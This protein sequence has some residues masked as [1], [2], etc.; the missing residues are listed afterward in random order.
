MKNEDKN[1]RMRRAEKVLLDM[2]TDPYAEL[3]PEAQAGYVA[4]PTQGSAEWR[5]TGA[6]RMAAA[7]RPQAGRIRGMRSSCGDYL[8]EVVAHPD[9]ADAVT[10]VARRRKGRGPD[11]TWELLPEASFVLRSGDRSLA[12]TLDAEG[13]IVVRGEEAGWLRD[14]YDTRPGFELSLETNDEPAREYKRRLEAVTDQRQLR[15]TRSDSF[16]RRREH[17][18][19]VLCVVALPCGRR[20]LSC[21]KKETLRLWDLDS[22]SCL[23]DFVGHESRIMSMAV[24]PGGDRALSG[25]E[26]ATLRLWDLVSGA[27]LR[28]FEGHESGVMSVAVLPGG[29]R[30]LSGSE[31]ATLRLWDLDSGACLRDFVGHESGIGSVAALACG[32][33]ALSGSLDATLRLWDLDSGACLRDFVGHESRIMSVTVLPSGDHALSGSEDAT[34]R[35]WDL[36]SGA[37]LRVFEGHENSI[38]SVAALPYGNYALTGSHDRTVRLWNLDTGACLDMMSLPASIVAIEPS[39]EGCYAAF[40]WHGG[41]REFEIVDPNA[42]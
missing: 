34:L 28:V 37:C 32:R 11:R 3:S 5:L 27:C 39:Q 30:A 41:F 18:S 33:R 7:P 29:D 40:D 23:R 1:E 42:P 9:G 2:L 36:A 6:P 22:C 20:A 19:D 12:L 26:D 35:L 15:Q 10:V 24:L 4:P 14:L 38:T 25:S 16:A 13:E 8:V 31:D 17:T 21:S